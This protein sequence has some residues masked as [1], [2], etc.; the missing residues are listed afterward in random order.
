MKEVARFL[1]KILIIGGVALG[2]AKMQAQT[3]APKQLVDAR[4]EEFVH[5]YM[6][7]MD[8]E[9]IAVPP[10]QVFMIG[11]HSKVKRHNAVGMAFGMFNPFAVVVALD[12][13][14]LNLDRNQIRWV[15]F[16]ELTHDLFDIRHE[17]GLW[18]MRP[19]MPDYVAHYDVERGICE[20]A[21]YLES[22]GLFLKKR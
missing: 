8:T 15:I 11:F 13:N 22:R 19:V 20:V 16:H 1:L 18:L 17:S 5:D 3:Y 21:D 7:L 4:I 14:I 10:Q 12:I 2:I 9:G 6:E